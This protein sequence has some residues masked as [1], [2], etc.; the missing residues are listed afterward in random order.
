MNYNLTIYYYNQ[1]DTQFMWSE[2]QKGM[3]P[4]HLLYG[5]THFRNH[6]IDMVMHPYR[7]FKSRWRLSLY[8]AW[9]VLT[10]RKHYDVLYGNA[11]RGLEILIFL[12]ALGL[13]RKPIVVWHHQRIKK[14]ANPLRELVARLFYRGIDEM[15]FFSEKLIADSLQSSKARKERLHMAHWGADMQYYDNL[16]AEEKAVR[17]ADAFI[18]TGKE[19]RDM[20]TLVEAFNKTRGQLYIYTSRA[21]L[22]NDYDDIFSRLRLE[23]NIHLNYIQGMAFREMSKKVNRAG[24]VVICCQ[25]SDYTVGLT[26][27]VEAL[28]LG[29]PII[30]T[31]NA[32]MPMDI[33]REKCGIWVD[34]G[35]V[36]GWRKA[37]N[38]ILDNPDKALEMGRNGRR[39]AE[40]RYNIERCTADMAEVIKATVQN[41]PIRR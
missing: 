17:Q 15:F 6:G 19:L 18:T 11:F 30:C 35:D 23:H 9:Q 13:Y 38:F 39:L 33:E 40:E 26:T 28:A 31:R 41:R 24:C 12:R 3:F 1:Q 34:V 16:M 4:G 27:V 5:A 2:W 14:A 22:G 37:I 32:Q 21:Y 8:N 36:E 20:P 29:L 25:Q 7:E 10:C